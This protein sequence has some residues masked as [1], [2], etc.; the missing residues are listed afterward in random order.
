MAAQPSGSPETYPGRSFAGRWSD[1]L[2]PASR[3]RCIG[4]TSV[5]GEKHRIDHL[6]Q[7]DVAAVVCSDI[8]PQFPYPPNERRGWEHRDREGQQ[9][10][11]GVVCLFGAQPAAVRVPSK[12]RRD[13]DP[14][15]IW[16][17]DRLSA[18]TRSEPTPISSR[19]CEN[20]CED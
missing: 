2:N 14:Q 13:F 1:G 20:G 3:S 4:Q 12:D 19:V 11:D 5:R 10:A 15:E 7:G 16:A 9:V 18:K 6:C 8:R 17:G